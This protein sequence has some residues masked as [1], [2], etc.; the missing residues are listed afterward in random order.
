MRFDHIRYLLK[1]GCEVP[2][3]VEDEQCRFSIPPAGI[4]QQLIDR[5][6]YR[7]RPFPEFAFGDENVLPFGPYE[8]VRLAFKIEGFARRLPLVLA[9]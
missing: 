9:I 3:A 4:A 6:R 5:F 1:N 2:I 8:Y 7:F